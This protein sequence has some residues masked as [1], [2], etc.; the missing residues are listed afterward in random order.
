L[1]PVALRFGWKLAFALQKLTESSAHNRHDY[2]LTIFGHG[3]RQVFHGN[4]V[5]TGQLLHECYA[6]VRAAEALCRDQER[7][8]VS[9]VAVYSTSSRLSL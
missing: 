9:A 7:N 2:V 6:A 4:F 1:T 5:G 8:S 3:S